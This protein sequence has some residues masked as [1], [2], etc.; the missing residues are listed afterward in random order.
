M[1]GSLEDAEDMVQ[2]TLLRAWR[3][4][5]SFTGRA[6]FRAWLY[7]I[8]TNACIDALRRRPRRVVATEAAAP[9]DPAA[10]LAPQVELPWLQPYPDRLL[11]AIPD[12]A[13]GPGEALVARETIELAFLAAIQHLP[14]RQRAVL[15]LRDALGW[16]AAEASALISASVPAVNSALQRARATMASRLPAERAEWSRGADA[17]ATERSLLGRYMDVLERHDVDALVALL[18]EDAR[19]A[20]PPHPAWFQGR[21]AVA[22]FHARN[23]LVAGVEWRCAATAANRQPACACYIRLEGERGFRPFSIDV[24][25]IEGGRIAEITAFLFPGLFPAF[26][27][28]PA[29]P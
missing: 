11:E 9:A 27:L 24:L 6:S 13:P 15:I 8:A 14:P 26:G 20:M 23:V 12:A 28:P 16:S 4:R 3:R 1:L 5:R 25:G 7:G 10:E 2:E 19:L 29:P 18:S 22:E 17:P 21:A